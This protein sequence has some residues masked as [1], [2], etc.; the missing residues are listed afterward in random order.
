M[1]EAKEV[2]WWQ[3]PMIPC[4]NVLLMIFFIGERGDEDKRMVKLEF[5]FSKLPFLDIY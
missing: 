4:N 1:G 5:L 2:L 3:G